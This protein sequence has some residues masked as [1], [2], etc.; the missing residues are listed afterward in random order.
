MAEFLIIS[1]DSDGERIKLGNSWI[2]KLDALLSKNE[3][4]NNAIRLKAT[5]FATT[6]GAEAAE[7]YLRGKKIWEEE[8]VA[9]R[10]ELAEIYKDEANWDKALEVLS[11]LEETG[12]RLNWSYWGLKGSIFL[13]KAF[14]NKSRRSSFVVYGPGPSQLDLKSLREAE[15]CLVKC[16]ENFAMIG[17]PLISS[18]AVV[19][20]TIVQRILGNTEDARNFCKSFLIQHPN[21][22]VVAGAF[23]GCA[24]SKD[25]LALNVKYSRIAYEANRVNKMAYQNYLISLYLTEDSEALLEL[26]LF[27]Q[28]NGFSDDHE[29]SLS[30]SLGA[31]SLNEIGEQDEALKQISF[32]KKSPDMFEDATVAEAVIS[33]NNGA[34]NKDIM[35]IYREALKIYPDSQILLTHFIHH[36]DS[37]SSGDAEELARCIQ[38]IAELRQLL[39]I[40]INELGRCYLTLTEYEKAFDVFK[41]GE[42]RYPDESRFL[43]EQ[44]MALS[45]VGDEEGVYK[46]LKK[47]LALGKKDYNVLRNFAFSAMQTGRLDEA[48]SVFQRA[49]VKAKNDSERAE[50]HC[51]LWELKRKGY[52]PLKDILRHVIQFGETVGDDPAKEAQFLMMGL[53]SPVPKETDSEIEEW[54]D[55]IR[56]RLKKFS[57]DHPRFPQFRSFKIPADIPDEEKGPHILAQIAEVML[58]HH[59]ATV[60]LIISSRAVPYPLS[61]RASLLPG[62]HSTFDY[63]THCVSSKEFSHGV[64]IWFDFNPMDSELTCLSKRDKVCVDLSALLTLAELGLLDLLPEH[65]SLIIIARGTKRTIDHELFRL[66]GPHPIAKAIEKW[67]LKYRSS[68]RIR[69]VAEDDDS[70]IDDIRYKQSEG[71]IFIQTERPINKLIG[72]GIGESTILAHELGIALYSDES[73]LRREALEEH[74]VNSFCTLSL[75]RKLR[76]EERLSEREEA[77]I[78]CEMIRKNYRVV[79]FDKAQLNCCLDE[80]IEK[81]KEKNGSIPTKEFLLADNDMGTIL[82]QF[83]DPFLSEAWLAQ[84]VASWWLS[85]LENKHLDSYILVEC[86]EY[87]CY[88]LSMRTTSGVVSGIKKHEQE[89]RLAHILGYFLVESCGINSRLIA[90]A[91]SAIKSCCARIFHHDERKYERTLFGFLP[92]WALEEV[93]KMDSTDDDR[94]YRIIMLTSHLPQEDRLRIELAIMRLNPSFL[95]QN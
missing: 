7:E 34:S 65:F 79:P 38:K 16:C 6:K 41:S 40:E 57:Q 5:W 85:L 49:V 58:P 77:T 20:L 2:K 83:G 47:Y 76:T 1:S 35:G 67:R 52:S 66:Q 19:N 62:V 51:Q 69:S 36:L 82:R 60:P 30:L 48:I 24:I 73:I 23:A 78:L 86:M 44:A 53:L 15:R 26:V 31:I 59:L 8:P 28:T 32:M 42:K 27:R 70:I 84:I 10:C 55:N 81:S 89:D 11:E 25:E 64:H 95:R 13:Q 9:T 80:L 45:Y 63:W 22:P 3:G 56:K 72:D 4:Y 50:L 68:I 88:A 74:K 39:P 71:G 87:P 18:M 75:L 94:S 61:F 29:K 21:D 91:W 43:Y 46:A 33:R 17:F 37:S 92:K 12:E 54:N 14:G 90:E 93:S